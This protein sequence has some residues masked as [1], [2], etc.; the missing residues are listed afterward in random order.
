MIDPMKLQFLYSMLSV[1]TAKMVM[2]L[3]DSALVELQLQL[4][5][6]LVQRQA[7]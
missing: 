5:V 2:N 7:V 3:R 4:R 6:R 1:I